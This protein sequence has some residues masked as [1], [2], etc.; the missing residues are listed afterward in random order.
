MNNHDLHDQHEEATAPE[1]APFAA[2]NAASFEGV[3]AI[4]DQLREALG[5]DPFVSEILNA[6]HLAALTVI[7]H[8]GDQYLDDQV[9]LLHDFNAAMLEAE[10]N[11]SR[12]ALAQK[13]EVPVERPDLVH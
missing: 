3:T 5:R 9:N 12:Y 8:I 4:A 10:S 6:L 2:I 7:N 13:M 1:T 11:L